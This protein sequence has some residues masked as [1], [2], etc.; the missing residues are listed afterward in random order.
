[1]PHAPPSDAASPTETGAPSAPARNRCATPAV[2]KMPPWAN[3][4]SIADALVGEHVHAEAQRAEHAVELRT[5]E[6]GEREAAVGG[7][8]EQRPPLVESGDRLAREVVVRE[9]A[10]GIR[11]AVER[12]A[13][14]RL[15]HGVGVERRS[16]SGGEATEQPDPRRELAGAVVAVHHGDRVAGGR[17]HEVELVVHVLRAAARARPS[18]RC[19]C[20]R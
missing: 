9:Q 18:R 16:R 1:M 15:E 12:L 4:R 7:A 8:D 5:H 3:I 11:F 20:R 10:A 2:R 13:E 6:V 17:R 14:E 19:S